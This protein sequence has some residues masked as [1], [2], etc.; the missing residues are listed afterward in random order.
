MRNR[1]VAVDHRRKEFV[2]KDSA[3]RLDGYEELL[4]GDH[5]WNPSQCRGNDTIRA[6]ERP[7]EVRVKDCG[8]FVTQ[9]STNSMSSAGL[10]NLQDS[11]AE[12]PGSPD[13]LHQSISAVVQ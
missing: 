12:V 13:Q 1:D 11:E 4:R 6:R 9:K 3:A 5:A 8:T 2:A 10:R 7:V